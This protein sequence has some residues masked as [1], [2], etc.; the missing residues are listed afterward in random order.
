MV[1]VLVKVKVLV[2]RYEAML[3]EWQGSLPLVVGRSILTRKCM[4]RTPRMGH[5]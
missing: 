3:A 5:Q 2:A 1:M 4:G